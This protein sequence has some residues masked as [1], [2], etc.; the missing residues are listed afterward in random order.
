MERDRVEALKARLGRGL[1][2][3]EGDAKAGIVISG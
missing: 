3:A 2:L 1:Y